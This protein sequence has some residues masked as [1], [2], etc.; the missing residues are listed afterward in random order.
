MEV[1]EGVSEGSAVSV[2]VAVCEGVDV[3]VGVFEDVA[4]GSNCVWITS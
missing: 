1:G 2:A 3:A 4:V